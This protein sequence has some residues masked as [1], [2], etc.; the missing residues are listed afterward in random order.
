MELFEPPTYT[1]CFLGAHFLKVNAFVSK[2]TD[3]TPSLIF[4]RNPFSQGALFAHFPQLRH[5]NNGGSLGSW[6][7]NWFVLEIPSWKLTYPPG[8]ARKSLT[9]KY[10][11]AMGIPASPTKEGTKW[12]RITWMSM[13]EWMSGWVDARNQF[14]NHHVRFHYLASHVRLGEVEWTFIR[15]I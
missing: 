2:L 4:L 5:G 3:C 15:C 8:E 13:N 12:H 1:W 7:Q 10:P 6:K 11:L 9:Q 14:T